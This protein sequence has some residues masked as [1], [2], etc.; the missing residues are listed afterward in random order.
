MRG[1]RVEV[2]GDVVVMYRD[3]GLLEIRWAVAKEWRVKLE[4]GVWP[5]RAFRRTLKSHY[6]EGRG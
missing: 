5:T 4:E 1:L 3:I 6:I 2:H